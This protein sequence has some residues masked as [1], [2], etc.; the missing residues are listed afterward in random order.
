VHRAALVSNPGSGMGRAAALVGPVLARLR[1][2]GVEVQ[3]L[4]GRDADDAVGLCRAAVA[5]GIDALVALGGDGMVH[6]ALQAVAGTSTP[7]GIIPAG[8]GNDFA[9]TL[10][11]PSD[12]LAA[13]QVVAAGHVRRI[14]AVGAAERWWCNVLGAG[15]DACVN[16]RANRIRWPKGKRRYDLAIAAELRTFR[17]LPFTLDLD[18]AVLETEAMLVAVGNAPTYGGGMR[19]TPAAIVDD[20]LLDVTVVG[21]VSRTTLVRIFPRIYRGT[22]VD[23]P[24]VSVHQVRCISLASPGQVA[25]ADGE[26]LG[27]LPVTAQI[28]AGALSVLVRS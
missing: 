19:I 21:P 10:G 6:L 3:H 26:R 4:Q 8:T 24:A 5:D 16:E 13:A 11:I 23:H 9:V 28:A 14:D 7:M 22:H 18:G 27:P 20:G 12:P 2:E 15:F 25:Y 1:D 17:P